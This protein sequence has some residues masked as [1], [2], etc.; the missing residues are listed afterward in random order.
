VK[1]RSPSRVADWLAYDSTIHDAVALLW[2]ER[3]AQ[4]PRGWAAYAAGRTGARW[5]TGPRL[6][7]PERNC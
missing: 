7:R 6:G 1:I 2:R 3:P 4:D 5:V